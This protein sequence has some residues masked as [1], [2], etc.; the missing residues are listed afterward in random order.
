MRLFLNYCDFN[1][2]KALIFISHT[3]FIR[4]VKDAEFSISE[5]NLCI[6][7]STALQMKVNLIKAISFEQ[8]CNL[9]S[10]LAELNDPRKFKRDA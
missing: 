8:F 4:I 7:M 5:N 6:M 3:T 10:A 1:V 2:Q 9:I